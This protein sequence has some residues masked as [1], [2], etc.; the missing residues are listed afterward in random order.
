MKISKGAFSCGVSYASLVWVL[1]TMGLQSA[2]LVKAVGGGNVAIWVQ[3][4]S[5]L[6]AG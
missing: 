6:V 3:N 1:V 2:N 4:A 5:T